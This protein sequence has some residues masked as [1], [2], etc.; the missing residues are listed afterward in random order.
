LLT[1]YL[2][3]VDDYEDKITV[4]KLY[5]KYYKRMFH[6]ALDVLQS[7]EDAEDA[8]HDS[9]IQ[10][11]RNIKF[12]SALD[13]DEIYPY[14][15]TIVRNKAIDIYRQNSNHQ[16]HKDKFARSDM[17]DDEDFFEQ[18]DYNELLKAITDLPSAYRDIM[19]LFYVQGMSAKEISKKLKI[20]VNAVWQRNSYAK[21]LLK[22]KLKEYDIYV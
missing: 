10:I 12:V 2:G 22:E 20:T 13:N 6:V 5:H 9:F 3:I 8:V 21:K 1:F 7:A 19:Y 11:S 16:K 15:I 4:E 14:I 17:K 18:I